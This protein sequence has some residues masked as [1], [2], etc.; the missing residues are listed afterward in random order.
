MS[1]APAGSS[2]QA[3]RP[4]SRFACLCEAPPRPPQRDGPR[5]G[6]EAKLR[7]DMANYD[8][9][10]NSW[11][12]FGLLQTVRDGRSVLAEASLW[13]LSGQHPDRVERVSPDEI[14]VHLDAAYRLERVGDRAFYSLIPAPERPLPPRRVPPPAPAPAPKPAAAPAAV[15]KPAAPAP[16][17]SA[18]APASK[19]VPTSPAAAK[20]A[21]PATAVPAD[22]APAAAPAAAAAKPASAAPPSATPAPAA[23]PALPAEKP[24]VTLDPVQ[25]QAPASATQP[26]PAAAPLAAPPPVVKPPV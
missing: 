10:E 5:P 7:A 15:A 11:K 23:S 25:V 20:P 19:A 13:Q 14:Y 2:R 4:S 9:F 12:P 17:A 22:A 6:R 24:T 18:P 16:A 21:A 26:S 3:G 1:S 8:P